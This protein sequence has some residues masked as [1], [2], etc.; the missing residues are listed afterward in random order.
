MDIDTVFN[1]EYCSKT[2]KKNGYYKHLK[3]THQLS[4]SLKSGVR[5]LTATEIDRAVFLKRRYQMKGGSGR[6][7]QAIV[8]PAL[9]PKLSQETD[10]IPEILQPD[11]IPE[12]SQPTPGVST[13]ADEWNSDTDL[14]DLC[15]LDFEEFQLEDVNSDWFDSSEP[16][17]VCPDDVTIPEIVELG[18]IP[19]GDAIVTPVLESNEPSV[20]EVE[21]LT[22]GMDLPTTRQLLATGPDVFI[23]NYLRDAPRVLTTEEVKVL[24]ASVYSA[25]ETASA[26][27]LE[28]SRVFSHRRH[29]YRRGK[30]FL[31]DW[32]V[33]DAVRR[34]H[35]HHHH[36]HGR[37][38][39]G[40]HHSL[41]SRELQIDQPMEAAEFPILEDRKLDV[42][43]FDFRLTN[44]QTPDVILNLGDDL[45]IYELISDPE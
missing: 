39:H 10:T 5:V 11:W 27:L 3:F 19:P 41:A 21:L 9:E 8:V 13:G 23:S 12:I 26:V 42:N 1:C 33:P 7:R 25:Y 38:H 2:F 40:Y 34:R 14:N 32:K 17:Q 31:A 15:A 37:H 36:H 6:K 24:W 45:R 44:S 35:H 30:E 43:D 4:F 20:V 28:V 29:I 16:L 18:F 22:F